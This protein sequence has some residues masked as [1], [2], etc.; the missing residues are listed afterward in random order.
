MF[1]QTTGGTLYTALDDERLA[2]IYEELGSRLGERKERRELTDVFA[3]GAAA[4][5]LAGGAIS[6]LLAAEGPVK[7]LL[8]LLARPPCR[9]SPAARRRASAATNE[10]RGLQVC[11]PIAGP[12]VVVPTA[13]AVPRPVV[14]FQLACPEGH[15]VGGLDAELTDRSIDISFAARLGSPVNPGISTE[16]SAL[17]TAL[18]TGTT[19]RVASFRPHSAASRARAAGAGSRPRCARSSPRASRRSAGCATVRVQAGEVRTVVRRCRPGERLVDGWHAL[20]FRSGTPPTAEQVEGLS[21][22][23]H[24]AR[25]PGG[26]LGDGGFALAAIRGL[27]QVGAVCARSR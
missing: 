9:P 17:F 24:A 6:F 11:V 3:G 26:R 5:L 7:R 19:A 22:E 2:Q 16:R 27:V 25:E 10:C 12:W 14:R 20:A 13:R 15:V 4:L 1:T 23:P 8:V 18:Y 21:G